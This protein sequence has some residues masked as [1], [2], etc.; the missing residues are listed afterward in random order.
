MQSKIVFVILHYC[1]VQSTIDAV[2]SIRKYS[3]TE[4]VI[5]DNASPD[6]S[7]FELLRK[8]SHAPNI[9]VILNQSNE[10]FARGNNIG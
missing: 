10:G 2:E 1:A 3:S 5:V 7:G 8:Y 9:Y 4:I 6:K